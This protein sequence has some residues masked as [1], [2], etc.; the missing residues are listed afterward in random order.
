M[1][2]SLHE[3]VLR[4]ASSAEIKRAVRGRMTSMRQDGWD[5]AKAGVT[6]AAEV[7]QATQHDDGNGNGNDKI[8]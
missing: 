3:M 8:I 2:E 5:K 6:T 7:L 4:E 1:N